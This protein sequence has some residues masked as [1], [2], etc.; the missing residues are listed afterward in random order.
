[1]GAIR[2]VGAIEKKSDAL[3]PKPLQHA[4]L[5]FG[6]FLRLNWQ[7]ASWLACFPQSPVLCKRDAGAGCINFG[8]LALTVAVGGWRGGL[9]SQP[10]SATDA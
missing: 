4:C 10:S 5:N 9:P 1:M 2:E 3:P 8:R 6:V 7:G